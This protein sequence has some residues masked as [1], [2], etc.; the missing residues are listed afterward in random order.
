M[1]KLQLERKPVND[2][3]QNFEQNRPDY[4]QNNENNNKSMSVEDYAQRS[5][6]DHFTLLKIIF[7]ILFI[8]VGIFAIYH[9]F[10]GANGIITQRS[11]AYELSELEYLKKIK[12]RELEQKSEKLKAL[13]QTDQTEIEIEAR[14]KG[15]IYPD[16]KIIKV[17]N[18]KE[19]LSNNTEE[20]P[21]TNKKKT[22]NTSYLIFSI[23]ATILIIITSYFINLRKKK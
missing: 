20:K 7:F 15:Y 3:N 8:G 10:Y 4:Q 22:D 17:I 14:K 9:I 19:T 13:H 5:Q 12:L 2:L 16:E 1:R 18:D 11:K 23:I 6:I 21:I